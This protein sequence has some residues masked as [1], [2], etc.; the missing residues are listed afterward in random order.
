[1]RRKDI[2]IVL[3]IQVL[4]LG[5]CNND[6]D[7]I[8]PIE[9]KPVVY[10]VFNP[11][12]TAYYVSLTKSFVGD[13]NAFVLAKQPDRVFFDSADI[14]LSGL[15]KDDNILFETEFDPY[16]IIK[17]PGIF[18]ESNGYLYRSKRELDEF[19]QFTI[20][21]QY[22]GITHFKLEI[23]IPGYDQPIESTIKRLNPA[24]IGKPRLD[25]IAFDFFPFEDFKYSISSG[26]S[27]GGDCL[28]FIMR[29]RYNDY[30]KDSIIMRET[31]ILLRKDIYHEEGASFYI[32]PDFFLNKLVKCIPDDQDVEYRTLINFDFISINAGAEFKMYVDTRELLTSDY[33]LVDW[34]NITNGIGLFSMKN[35][36]YRYDYT[37]T[38]KTKDSIAFSPVTA[39]LRFVRW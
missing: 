26:L 18:P 38:Q 6:M 25:S 36:F 28:D 12:D 8:D 2:V 16:D 17:K 32:P 21:G 29:L 5:S 3:L 19:E 11:M 23:R 33:H 22:S 30:Y 4:L 37:F 39:H 10:C 31:D 7:L 34:S 27:D 24:S 15:D 35:T 1:M 20:S 13:T 14:R 9:P